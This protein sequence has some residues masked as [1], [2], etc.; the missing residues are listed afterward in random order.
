MNLTADARSAL[1]A[2]GFSRRAFL[3]S[4]GALVV[5]F[6]SA[7]VAERFGMA[8]A[9]RA[10]APAAGER[11]DSWLAIAADGHVTAYTGKC[12]LGQGLFTAQAQLVAEELSVPVSRVTLIQCDTSITPDQGTTSGA[13][14]HPTNFNQGALALAAASAREALVRLAA[15]RLGVPAAQLTVTDGVVRVNGDA[16]RTVSYADLIGGR[17][18]E[19][20][21][22]PKAQRKPSSSWTVLGTS[23]PRLDIPGLVTAQAEFV[24]TVRVPGMLH[25]RV[26]RPPA[27]GATLTSVDESPVARMPGVVR[28]V[29]Q[30]NFVGIVAE[31]PWQAMQAAEKLVVRWGAGTGLPDP[32]TSYDAL[33]TAPSRDTVVV[34]SGDVDATFAKAASVV[35][36][37]YL[38]P[39]QMH[40]SLGTSCAVVDVQAPRVTVW[41]SSQNVHALRSSVALVLGLK[42]EDVR[43]IFVRGS[44]CYGINGADT[45]AFDAALL[46]AAVGR[47]VRVQLSRRDEMAWENF[48]LPFVIDQRVA[49]DASGTIIA[50]EYEGWSA[51]RG[52][53]P[54]AN[55]PGNVVTG[56]LAGFQPAAFAPRSPAPMPTTFVAD[57]NTAPSYVRGQVGDRAGGVGTVTSER[58]ISHR[59]LS[60][61]FT[62]PLRAPERLQNT[63]AHECFIDEVAAHAKA[64]PVE[65]RL[66]HIREARL[67][68]VVKAAARTAGWQPGPSPQTAAGAR[69]P[70]TGTAR[71]RGF[72][73]VACETDNSFVAMVADIEVNRSTGL[74]AV[75]RLVLAADHGPISNPDGLR[76]QLEGG[77]L[78]GVSRAL[79]EEVTWDGQRVTASDWSSYRTVAV[80]APIPRIDVVLINQPSGKAM[81]AGETSITVSAAAISNALFNATGVRVRQVPFTPAR[82]RTAFAART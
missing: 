50:Y 16:G 54:G 32:R 35:R 47:P 53:R 60:P 65:Y 17:R 1:V 63:Y 75:T 21:V 36:A 59:V 11:L 22:D 12:E 8:P 29:V 52:G 27:V 68:E 20:A 51:A 55:N 72:A 58:V 71:G 7:S 81:G 28:V 40:G 79:A 48:G 82:V 69:G 23:V 73:C 13:Q 66:R 24:H 41:A 49:L 44:G 26:V 42:R 80:G 30:N 37:T 39:Y 19:L 15:E 70:A 31:K 43:V 5:A 2:S 9:L 67:A 62:G 78:H 38:H 18:F 6:S 76:N 74:I 14:S 3:K 4:S 33:R 34:D 57:N 77:A 64:D 46:S 56:F 45:V 10:Q 25:G 61:F